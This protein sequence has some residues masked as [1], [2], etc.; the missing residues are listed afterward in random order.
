MPKTELSP[1]DF[2][3]IVR[4][5]AAA[6]IDF[7]AVWCGPCRAVAPHLD[8]IADETEYTICKC[9]VDKCPDAASEFGIKVIPTLV[10]VKNGNEVFRTEGALSKAEIKAIAEKYLQ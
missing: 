3:E 5:S 1:L 6:I 7:Y 10:F 4:S 8:E 2:N 9:D